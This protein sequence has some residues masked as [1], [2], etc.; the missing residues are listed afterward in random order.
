MPY[1]RRTSSWACPREGCSITAK[2]RKPEPPVATGTV[3]PTRVAVRSDTE[4]DDE[5][6]LTTLVIYHGQSKLEIDVTAFTEMLVEDPNGDTTLC[7]LVDT[8]R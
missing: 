6:E 2:K 8:E 4:D 1:S 7:L 5:S 3:K